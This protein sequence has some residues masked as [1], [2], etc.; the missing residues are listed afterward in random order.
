M[1]DLHLGRVPDGSSH[2]T[3]YVARPAGGGPWPGVVAI[4]EGWGLDA[5]MRRQA[6]RLAAAGYLTLAPN[7]F[8]DGG[9][10]R[11]VV[12]TFLAMGRVRGRPFADIEAS[13][14]WL[15]DQADCTGRAGVIGFCMGGGF[16]LLTANSGFDAASVNYGLPPRDMTT[17]LRQACPIVASYGGKEPGAALTVRRLE[18][19]LTG[20]GIEHDVKLYPAAGHSFLNDAPNGPALLRPLLRVARMGPEPESAADAWRRIEAFFAAHLSG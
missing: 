20:L 12:S 3:G 15:L 16:A 6:D 18:K 17:A 4:H 10:M 9:A 2:L 5:V 19:T 7:L 11:C 8:S 1:P 13:R 14:Q